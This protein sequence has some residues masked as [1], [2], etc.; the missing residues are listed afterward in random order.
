MDKNLTNQT[1]ALAGLAQAVTLVQQIAKRGHADQEAM[2]V[3][4]AS[5]LKVDADDILDVY[6]GLAGLK[7]GL[8]QLERQLTEPRQ[9]DP[10]LAR[11]AS[12][13]MYLEQSVMKQ[14]TMTK[15][16]GV[17]VKRAQASAEKAGQ[18]VNDEVFEALA[19][20]YQQ[21]LSQLKPRVLVSGEQRHLSDQRNGDRIRAML[22]AAVRSA[23]LWR[24]AGGVRWKFLFI[25]AKL[26][27][28]ARRLLDVIDAAKV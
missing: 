17:A 3:S 9:V 20:G 18:V 27:R 4:I 19:Y 10:E 5:T 21:T 28:E 15:A 24:Q 1:I 14:P 13:L 22:L 6:G 11:Y 16:I 12:T 23:L 2:E 25:R 26:Q 8:R 7:T